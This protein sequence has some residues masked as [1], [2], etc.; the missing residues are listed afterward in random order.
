[1]KIF[2]SSPGRRVELIKI[3]KKEIVDVCIIG[4]DY[5]SNSPAL[6]YCDKTYKLPFKVDDNYVKEVLNICIYEKVDL[7]IP[8][9]DPELEWYAKY[10][11]IFNENQIEVMISSYESITISSDKLNT[12]MFFNK[13]DFIKNPYT[14][15][16]KSFNEK[17]FETDSI[18]LKPKNGSSGIGIHKISK[19]YVSDFSKIMDLDLEQYIVQEYIDFD[20]ETTTDVFIDSHNQMIEL[21]QRKRLKTRGGEVERAITTKNKEI[22]HIIKKIIEKTSFFGVINIQ[23]MAKGNQYYI[24]EINPRFGGGFPLAYHSGANMIEHIKKLVEKTEIMKYNDSRYENNFS[25]LRFDDAIYIRGL[26]ND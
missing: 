4:G 24:G 1:M 5:S 20:Y 6:V 12:F 22:T 19:K 23:I 7:V 17:E 2:F 11:A 18:I 21:C 15:L 16:L 14:A 10:K 25:M 13:F 26:K 8:L 3:F 9:I